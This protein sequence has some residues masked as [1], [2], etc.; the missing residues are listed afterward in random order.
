MSL[1]V[2]FP[3]KRPHPVARLLTALA[4][5]YRHH[6]WSSDIALLLVGFLVMLAYAQFQDSIDAV[7]P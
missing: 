1:P 4:K 3:T 2:K 6:P 5:F 7:L